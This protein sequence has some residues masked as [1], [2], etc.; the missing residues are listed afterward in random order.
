VYQPR[1]RGRLRED[2]EEGRNINWITLDIGRGVFQPREGERL[3][4]CEGDGGGGWKD[5]NTL[6]CKI[7]KNR[8]VR[9]YIQ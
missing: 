8:C 7:V 5:Y 4:D 3:T 1:E 6:N 2:R 9:C